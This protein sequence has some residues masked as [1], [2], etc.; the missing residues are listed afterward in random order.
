MKK[1]RDRGNNLGSDQCAHHNNP[2]AIPGN[3]ATIFQDIEEEIYFLMNVL[4]IRTQVLAS[5]YNLNT[6]LRD[7]VLSA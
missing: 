1:S 3:V 5:G 7:E 4:I 2:N 6:T